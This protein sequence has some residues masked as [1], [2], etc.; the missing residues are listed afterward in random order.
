MRIAV[1]TAHDDLLRIQA[2]AER[3][4]DEEHALI[5]ASHLMLLKDP[6]LLGRID[7]DRRQGAA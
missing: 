2:A 7:G 1:E 6:T 3:E 5:F 4:I